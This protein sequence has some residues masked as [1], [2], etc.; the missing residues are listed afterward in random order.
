MEY[1][2]N[3]GAVPAQLATLRVRLSRLFLGNNPGFVILVLMRERLA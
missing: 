2:F 1:Y 3:R